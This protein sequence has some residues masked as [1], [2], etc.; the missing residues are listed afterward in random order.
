[1]CYTS[2]YVARIILRL[3][4][5]LLNKFLATATLGTAPSRKMIPVEGVSPS[6]AKSFTV[7]SYN[8]LSKYYADSSRYSPDVIYLPISL[9]SLSYLSTN[10]RLASPTALVLHVNGIIDELLSVIMSL[11]IISLIYYVHKK[12]T[13]MI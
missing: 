8:I 2:T 5:P 11:E 9:T 1:M 6:Q 4:C 13:R 3:G 10:L 12:Q 7:M